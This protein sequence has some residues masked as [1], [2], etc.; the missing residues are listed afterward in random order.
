MKFFQAILVTLCLARVPR[1]LDQ[2]YE[3]G[4][5]S[6]DAEEY[7]VPGYLRPDPFQGAR[8]K[9]T[10]N[11]V[12]AARQKA[13]PRIVKASKNTRTPRR[14]WTADEIAKARAAPKTQRPSNQSISPALHRQR[15]LDRAQKLNPVGTKHVNRA[16]Y[17]KAQRRNYS[18]VETSRKQT[19]DRSQRKLNNANRFNPAGTKNANR[20]T[21]TRAQRQAYGKTKAPTTQFKS[22]NDFKSVTADPD[23][24][25]GFKIGSV[26]RNMNTG[27]KPT[28]SVTN[29]FGARHGKNI[30]S[31]QDNVFDINNRFQVIL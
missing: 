20:A 3:N 11:E 9:W 10:A 15:K 13:G 14:K 5:E 24:T 31:T 21:Y 17:T 7:N 22:P 16:K 2:D 12:A 27:I 29:A 8:R 25:S 26:P 4:M 1:Y 30:R 19:R 28:F 6:F 18:N 23:L